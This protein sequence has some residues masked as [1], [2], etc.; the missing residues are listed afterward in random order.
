V[1]SDKIYTRSF[2]TGSLALW[3][4]LIFLPL[5]VLFASA[6]HPTSSFESGGNFFAVIFRSF[7]LAAVIAFVAVLLGWSPGRLFGT[8]NKH[9]DL[10]LLLLIL[11][12]V[13]PRYVLYYAWTL[14]LSPTTYLGAYLSQRIE[15]ARF[16]GNLT[17]TCVL[18][19]WYWPIAALLISQGWRR[20]D[21]QI[22]DSASLDADRFG[23]FT[24]ITLPLLAR[25][26]LLAFGVCFVLCLSEFST[27]QLAG[28]ET[29][30][31]KLAVLY[32]ETGSE[33]APV[34][35]SW[36]V[37]IAA[38]ILAVVLGT[39]NRRWELPSPIA[40]V[41]CHKQKQRWLFL[42]VLI[43]FSLIAPVVLLLSN[44]NDLQPLRQFFML[45]FD[46]LSW[47][48]AIASVAAVMAYLIAFG[49]LSLDR[50]TAGRF[51]RSGRLLSLIMR[52]SIFL[53]MLIPA[54]IV[55]VSLLKILSVSHAPTSL[56]Q[57]WFIV[58]AGQAGRFA[59]VALILLL[60]T[61]YTNSRSLSEMASLDGTSP[62]RIWWHI[63][64]PYIWP[65][66]IGSFILIVMF[67][68]TELSATMILLPAGLPNFAQRLLNQMHYARDQQVIASCLILICTFFILTSVI[69]LLLRLIRLRRL[70]LLMLAFAAVSSLTGCKDK[71][72]TL[73]GTKF[74]ETFGKTGRGQGEFI[75]P[76]AIDIKNDNSLFIVDKTGRIQH[77]DLDGN[78]LNM[79]QMPQI[80]SGKPTGLSV[81]P[82][83]NLYVA[84]TH[85]YRVVVFSPE[86]K[87][88][89]QWGQFGKD[90]GCFIYPTDVAFSDDGRIFVSEYGGNDRISVFN[91]ESDFLYCFGSPGDGTGQL[92]RPSALC[93]DMSRGRLYVADACNHRIAIYN[94]DGQLSGYIG[95]AGLTAGKLRYP[96]DL[97][98]FQDGTLVVCEYGNNRIQL[99][100]PEGQSIAVYGR[101]GRQLG[102]LAYPWGLAIDSHRRAYVID[103]GN[104]RIQ[105][106]Q[107]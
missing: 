72:V 19:L 22:W 12:L 26:V 81:G 34:R 66:F 51:S 89:R 104:N 54:S 94:F 2:I 3:V 77:F 17:S 56:R 85:Y 76:R 63:H 47:S 105:V 83:G 45:H 9:R 11:P 91:A 4:L 44:L 59:G 68:M 43:G 49:A 71:S 58:S 16:I 42:F 73:D 84:D 27:F 1:S 37:S 100:S 107:L 6:V 96:Y 48:L 62:F 14:I 79:I 7:A 52:T 93:V 15:L 57:S 95:S 88:L 92:A 36:P 55:G 40:A 28:V 53:T 31:T 101:A 33:A 20:I 38:L 13:L 29:I 86:G 97:A 18:I 24:K 50:M 78:F 99:F 64:L 102:E 67:G 5:I 98:I 35:A 61:R 106:W 39:G 10:L 82:D 65:L 25:P 23:T 30:G 41:E 60:L 103:S 74:L 21:R 87:M 8:S 69:I 90:E 80:E 75:Y 32:E 70:I 46:E